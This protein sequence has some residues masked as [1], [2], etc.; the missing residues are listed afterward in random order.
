MPPPPSCN[1]RCVVADRP[2]V[3]FTDTSP[4]L[5]PLTPP[6]TGALGASFAMTTMAPLLLPGMTPQNGAPVTVTD[7]TLALVRASIQ[8]RQQLNR[9]I[10]TSYTGFQGYD[11]KG[12]AEVVAPS[13]TMF[14]SSLPRVNEG[15]YTIH[16]FNAI[17]KLGWNGIQGV[18]DDGGVAS[19]I[20]PTTVQLFVIA[21]SI[22]A[23]QS[24]TF[25][26]EWRTRGFQGDLKASM[27]S[28][29]LY[30]LKL[31]E[32]NWLIS[33]CDYL[34]APPAPLPPTTAAT[35]GTVM[36]C[37]FDLLGVGDVE[38][39]GQHRVAKTSREIG[40]VCQF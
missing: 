32:E 30:S 27:M 35:G 17:T 8:E 28:L 15:G 13:E 38:G 22:A 23:Q 36:N 6:L 10:D 7:E 20:T 26:E 9:S 40:N 34:W 11:L 19:E 3:G 5:T 4:L 29:L 31:I 16:H 14:G 21:Q 2:A 1:S 18:V 24:I 39:E 33:G 12:P 37:L 25:Q